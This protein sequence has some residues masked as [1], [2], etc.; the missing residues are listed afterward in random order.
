[1]AN[2]TIL[3]VGPAKVAASITTTGDYYLSLNRSRS[4]LKIYNSGT[5]ILEISFG[6]PEVGGSFPL[7]VG[8]V[9]EPSI[10]PPDAVFIASASGTGA[11]VIYSN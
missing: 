9:Y 2:P 6:I 3:S 4:F 11:A 1:M 8:E 7:A 10:V 5:V